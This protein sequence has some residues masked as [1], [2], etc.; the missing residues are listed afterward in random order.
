M[1]EEIQTSSLTSEKFKFTIYAPLFKFIFEILKS[2]LDDSVLLEFNQD[3]MEVNTLT[4]DHICH[5]IL[6]VNKDKFIKYPECGTETILFPMRFDTYNNILQNVNQNEY[7]GVSRINSKIRLSFIDINDKEHYRVYF[8]PI[9]EGLREREK[10]ECEWPNWVYVKLDTLYY[11]LKRIDRIDSCMGIG[12]TAEGL[13]IMNSPWWS[14][15]RNEVEYKELIKIESGKI[16]S[17]AKSDFY[18]VYLLDIVSTLQKI[19]KE[20]MIGT[21]G[22]IEDMKRIEI[23]KLS[24]GDDL[25]LKIEYSI[26]G[27]DI[28]CVIGPKKEKTGD[29]KDEN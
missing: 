29:D 8:I 13:V 20:Y 16:T 17:I 14:D 7:V 27:I 6:R 22:N 2:C 12:I 3:W 11:S 19:K 10:V 18:L 4:R 21:R 26:L 1:K 5:I 9:T 24:I 25:P 28:E 23:V 15:E